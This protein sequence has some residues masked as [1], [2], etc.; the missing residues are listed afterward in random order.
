MIKTV[1]FDID[2]TML[3][4][5]FSVFHSLRDTIVEIKNEHVELDRL[6]F[7]LGIPGV[8][9]LNELGIETAEGMRIWTKNVGKYTDTVSLFAGIADVIAELKAAGC[10]LGIITSKTRE[11]YVAEFVPHG[12]AGYFDHVVCAGESRRPK[13]Y[14][15]PMNQFLELSGADPEETIYI[16]DTKYDLDC[17]S[18]ANVPFGLAL[19]GTR[20][21]ASIHAQY[22]FN[23]PSDIPYQIGLAD[24]GSSGDQWIKHAMELQFLAQGGITYS[25][26]RFDIERFERI[27][28]IS[29]EMLSSGSGY[30][31]EHVKEIFCNEVGFQTPKLDTR[32]A[33]FQDNKILLVE[34][35][36]GTWSLP[37]GWVDV[38][39]SIK[40]NT[41]KEVKEEAGLDVVPTLLIAVQDRNLHN[42]PVYAYGVTKVFVLCVAIDGEFKP[43]IETLRSDYFELGN[44]PQLAVEKNT[45]AQIE[46]C[47]KASKADQWTTVFD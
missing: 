28:E 11:Q 44:L 33:I 8:S 38:N 31:K 27:R 40:S 26:D 42:T 1:V 9:V 29:A 43:N 20:N 14:P 32:A 35:L 21:A 13:P 47:F 16:G 15:D 17:A 7:A 22:Y 37:G 25:R 5:S 30:P 2:G 4:T 12:I 6:H 3:D 36:N 10:N 19:W 24:S 18:G 23:S 41:I 39:E 34:E 46:L 45:A